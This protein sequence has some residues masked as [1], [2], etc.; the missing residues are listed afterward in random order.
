MEI[1]KLSTNSPVDKLLEGGLEAGAVTNVYGPPGS[2]KTNLAISSA[3]ACKGKVVYIDTEGSFSLERFHQLGGDEKKLKNIIMIEPHTWKE[4]LVA[5]DN[6]DKLFR[7]EK[8]ELIIIDS[9]V[10]LYR[11]ELSQDNFSD[12]NRQLASQYCILSRI[13]REQKIP[14]LV[15]N[16]VYSKGD[17][18]EVSS[19]SVAR[20][21]SKCLIELKRTEKDNHRLAILRKHRAL[22]EGRKIEFEITEKG[23]KA[24]KF[25]IF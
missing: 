23:L 13:G 15:T 19:K 24:T 16:Q 18:V 7:N 3:L 1:K 4:Q 14:V 10:A 6:L 12:I 20:Y 5:V 22:P 2:G 11:L 25:S 9:V 17:E 8:I 21:W